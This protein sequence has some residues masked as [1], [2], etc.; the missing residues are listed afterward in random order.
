MSDASSMY[1]SKGGPFITAAR[2]TKENPIPAY[3][4]RVTVELKDYLIGNLEQQLLTGETQDL[5]ATRYLLEQSRL[6]KEIYCKGK[7]IGSALVE[8]DKS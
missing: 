5:A 3:N 6:F 4:S 8:I 2:V 7:K 1:G